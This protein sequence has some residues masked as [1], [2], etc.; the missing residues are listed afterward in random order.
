MEK[1]SKMQIELNT[2]GK[3]EGNCSYTWSIGGYKSLLYKTELLIEP[4]TFKDG[5]ISFDP[6]YGK[7]EQLEFIF[8]PIFI[9][10]PNPPAQVDY[11]NILL[12]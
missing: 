12:Y 9:A 4:K 1:F 2:V 3:D 6:K 8:L 11:N 5:L 10:H 7:T